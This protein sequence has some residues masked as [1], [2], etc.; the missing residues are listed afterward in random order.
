MIFRQ[1]LP[2]ALLFKKVQPQKFGCNEALVSGC[3]CRHTQKQQVMSVPW[4]S[5]L[6]GGGGWDGGREQPA[7]LG[8]AFLI[9]K[10]ERLLSLLQIPA[11]PPPWPTAKL[12][13]SFSSLCGKQAARSPKA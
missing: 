5:S 10:G 4:Q 3:V 13:E 2:F 9:I 7:L 12:M 8:P 6:G 11:L 1:H